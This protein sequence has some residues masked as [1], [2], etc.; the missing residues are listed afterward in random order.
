ML[1]SKHNREHPVSF[2]QKNCT[3]VYEAESKL[4][5]SQSG[6]R[7]NLH[8]TEQCGL[9]KEN[10]SI[11]SKENYTNSKLSLHLILRQKYALKT[12]KERIQVAEELQSY[13]LENCS[14]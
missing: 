3:Y 9:N 14:E 6:K 2:R 1:Q 12:K 5:R 10:W 8:S 4:C 11:S 7:L 13:I